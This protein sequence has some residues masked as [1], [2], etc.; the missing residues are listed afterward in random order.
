V[1][2]R[3]DDSSQGDRIVD[4]GSVAKGCVS[5]EARGR[6]RATGSPNGS[7]Q[8]WQ[9]L[10]S[11]RQKA[12][13]PLLEGPNPSFELGARSAWVTRR[14]S[15]AA[16]VVCEVRDSELPVGQEPIRG[17]AHGDDERRQRSGSFG[18]GSSS[19]RARGVGIRGDSSHMGLGPWHVAHD[20]RS[21][22]RSGVTDRS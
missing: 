12:S 4:R 6:S 3:G 2:K 11:T 16:Q 13:R 9:H 21:K 7:C 1:R 14:I 17:G 5:P 8:Q 19:H 22:E 10:V 20:V 18:K 15:A